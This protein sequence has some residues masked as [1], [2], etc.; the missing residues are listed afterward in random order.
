M[1]SNPFRSPKTGYSPQSVTDRIDRVVRMNKAE[2]EAALNVPGI[3]KTVV[4]KIRSRLKAMEKDHAD[5]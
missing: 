4:N 5:R 3:Q 1:S 2:L